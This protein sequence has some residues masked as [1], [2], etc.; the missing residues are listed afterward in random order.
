MAINNNLL[1]TSP[2]FQEAIIDKTTGLPMVAGVVTCYHD[3]SRTTL[4]NWYY[5]S[6]SVAPYNYIPLP[7]PLTLSAAGSVTDI[8]GVDTMP[9]FYPYLE[10]DNS[11]A[12]PYYITI[13]NQNATNTITR[14][15]FPFF[16][17]ASSIASNATDTN[18]LIVNGEFWRNIG[19][20]TLTNGSG[21]NAV[22]VQ[23]ICPSQHDSFSSP[24][25]VMARSNTTATDVV[26]FYSFPKL[27]PTSAPTVTNDITPEYYLQS[28]CSANGSGETYKFIQI[29]I[30]LHIATVAGVSAT[31]TMQA[32]NIGATTAA[33]STVTVSI[34]QYTG[35][36]SSQ[37][38]AQLIGTFVLTTGWFKYTST[39]TFQS[40]AGLSLGICN[41]D[42]FYLQIGMPINT[43][44][45]INIAK[46]SIYLTPN[47][48]TNS[49]QTYDQISAI[50]NSPRTGDVRASLNGWTPWGWVPANDGTIGSTASLATTRANA[51]TFQLYSLIWNM[52]KNFSVTGANPIAGMFNPSG[53]LVTYGASPY[54]DFAA[55]NFLQLTK[56]LGRVMLG[57][58][59]I[60][61]LGSTTYQ[62]INNASVSPAIV[63]SATVNF[64]VGQ[65]IT[66]V[67]STGGALPAAFSTSVVYYVCT[68][69]G[70]NTISI[71]S[72]YANALAGVALTYVGSFSGIVFVA[73]NTEGA[74]I[75]EYG[76]T[77]LVTEL[78]AHTHTP[79]SGSTFLN[80]GG[81][82]TLQTG[83]GQNAS[84]SSTT[85]STGSS[86]P[87]NI[88][89]PGTFYNIFFKL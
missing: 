41:D 25:I 27:P 49:F 67:L 29:P 68:F 56:M 9:F 88:V 78:A 63:L 51:D 10:T 23:T 22:T 12:D 24:D 76:H 26:N 17:P 40:N 69:A 43:S 35:T 7:N 21:A 16:P 74:F 79:G 61:S 65:P 85:G 80:A 44:Y 4:K 48:P 20:I 54:A 18:N 42:A 34:Y 3:N 2:T 75:G 8:N 71:S 6:G 59:P 31:F 89:Q 55:N 52:G 28:Y 32:Q 45:Q 64:W 58:V 14:E 86:T 36:G 38:N 66:F 11:T 62:T 70:G 1:V 46:P 84:T 37:S 53:S 19:N 82:V 87:F 47:P 13:V 72:S 15:N 83:A 77:Q 73:G 30:S 50:I 57:T 33:A 60:G 5:Q 81:G 39:F